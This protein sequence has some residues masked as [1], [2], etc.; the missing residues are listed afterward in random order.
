MEAGLGPNLTDSCLNLPTCYPRPAF[1]HG[2]D[3]HARS[4]PL[5]WGCRGA[6]RKVWPGAESNTAQL[7]QAGR[8]CQQ[9]QSLFAP[10]G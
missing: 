7:V 6:L 8:Q 2:P 5:A 4:L 1:Q 10:L 9:Q 3:V